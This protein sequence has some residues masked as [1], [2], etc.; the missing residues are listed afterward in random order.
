[1]RTDLVGTLR[2]ADI[3]RSVS[4]CGW[5][6]RRREHGEHLA[7]VDLRDH[8]GIVQC[9]VDNATDVRSGLWCWIGPSR[10]LV[11]YA[12]PRKLNMPTTAMIDATVN[13][14]LRNRS[15]RSMGERARSSAITNSTRNTAAT[16]NATITDGAPHPSLWPWITP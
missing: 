9:V 16:T 11:A 4:L 1:M 13:A 6:A 5:V 3:G 15:S 12:V 7:F 14:L 8:T 10:M 2:A